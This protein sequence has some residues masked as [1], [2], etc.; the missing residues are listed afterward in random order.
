MRDAL[1]K[2]MGAYRHLVSG[3]L[4]ECAQYPDS[5]L[6]YRPGGAGWSAVQTMHHLLLSE[7]LSLQYVQKKLS[8]NPRL[9]TRGVGA[10]WRGFLLWFYLNTPFKFKA[11]DVVGAQKLPEQV[12][13]ADTRARWEAA[14]TGW[15]HF[16]Q[17]MPAELLDKAVYR[18]PL[19][20]RL[21][22][23]ETIGFFRHHFLRHRRQIRK[24]I[25]E[26]RSQKA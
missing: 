23:P 4:D 6:N 8:F 10:H 1:S 25:T 17:Q 22:W 16:I 21:G 12:S 26:A 18:H 14:Q 9:E 2:K 20:G 3:L 19:A 13:L 24:A 5:T 15:E 7:E 11:P